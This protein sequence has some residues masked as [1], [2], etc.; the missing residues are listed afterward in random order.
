MTIRIP[1]CPFCKNKLKCEVKAKDSLGRD[2]TCYSK[3]HSYREWWHYG[4][5]VFFTTE[6]SH[7]S[8]V[9]YSKKTSIIDLDP[10][11]PAKADSW[12]SIPKT[13]EIGNST[14]EKYHQ[15]IL[16]LINFS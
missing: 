2:L 12:I 8:T 6:T 3:D 14:I 10:N 15:K 7:Y 16:G 1:N 4:K 5:M 9:T 13:I 11:K